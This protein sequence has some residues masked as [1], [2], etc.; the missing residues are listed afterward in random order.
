MQGET[1][2]RKKNYSGWSV[3]ASCDFVQRDKIR[4]ETH[5]VFIH[6]VMLLCVPLTVWPWSAR[7]RRETA[8]EE[9]RGR[10]ERTLSWF[11][12][13][14]EGCDPKRYI[15]K[16]LYTPKRVWVWSHLDFFKEIN[17]LIQQGFIKLIKSNS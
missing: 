3:M 4:K 10:M 6:S 16:W 5:Y 9:E 7:R 14:N 8:G 1:I 12:W 17:N 13:Q 11:L 15:N 2:G